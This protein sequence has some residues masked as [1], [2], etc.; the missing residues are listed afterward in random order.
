MSTEP[1]NP[2]PPELELSPPA[3]AVRRQSRIGIVRFS[4]PVFLGALVLLL[5]SVPFLD[6]FPHGSLIES[7]LMSL[8]LTSAVLAVGRRRRTLLIALLLWIPAVAA[9]WGHHYRPDLVPPLWY[10]VAAVLF[11]SFV[12]W[13]FLRFILWAPRVNVDVLCA[14]IATYLLLGLLWVLAYMLVAAANPVAF[15]FQSGPESVRTMNVFNAYY[16]SFVTL[17]TTGYGDITPVSNA[18]RSLA[19]LEGITGTLYVAV[20]IARL[21][22][23]YSSQGLEGKGPNPGIRP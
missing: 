4:P 1:M 3:E 13:Q 11:L 19:V 9:R 17:S 20:L 22:A 8:M 12:V 21:V 18:A 10:P 7:G 6:L 5:A 15:S 23:L 2:P 14:G 16:F